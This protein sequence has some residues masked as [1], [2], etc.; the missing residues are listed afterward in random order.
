[1]D[2]PGNFRPISVVFFLVKQQQQQKVYIRV[3]CISSIVNQIVNSMD[4][5]DAV[6]AACL[7]FERHLILSVN[8]CIILQSLFNMNVCTTVV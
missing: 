5:G 4:N 2:Y 6:C 3:S 7:D 1:M 8:H